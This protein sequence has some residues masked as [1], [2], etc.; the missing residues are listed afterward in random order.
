MLFGVL[1][2]SFWGYVIATLILT[3]ITI[4]GVTIYLHRHQAHRALDL[5][6]VI[7]HFFRFWLWLTTGMSTR[8]WVAIHRK[9][10]ATCE[11]KDDPHSPI[12]LGL[13]KL[14]LEG[15]ELYKKEAKNPETI[16]K[17]GKGTPNDW[18]ENNLYVPHCVMGL[19]LM[20]IIDLILFGLPGIS[21]WGI[22]MIWIPFWAAGVINGVGHYWGYRN[23]E[24][25]D[26]ATNIFPWGILIGGE[27]LHNNHHT[28]ASSAKLSVKW[29]EFDIGWAYIKLFSWLG[30]AKVKKLP[31]E[32]AVA[33]GKL[34]IDM[35]TIRAVFSN[36]FQ[37]MAQY[38]KHVVDPVFEAEKEQASRDKRPFFHRTRKLLTRDQILMTEARKERLANLLE[39]DGTLKQVY[40]FRMKLQDIWSLTA[41]SQKD[42]IAALQQ[43]CKE[44]EE[45]GIDALKQF[46]YRLKSLVPKQALASATN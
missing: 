16:A 45:T 15:A 35:D 37:I 22:Q 12:I 9:H 29:W 27:E 33:P 13:K 43:W 3:H 2:L 46:S 14:L 5:H 30:L 40:Q 31:P 18:L 11:T 19:T 32:I 26:A 42:L 24:C 23:Y 20:M 38:A 21:I 10:H 8:A 25:T 17:Y 6:P 34:T 7:A 28:F 44:A 4:L 1:N 41:S 36:R 39:N